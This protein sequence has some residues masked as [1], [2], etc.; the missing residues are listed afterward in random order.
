MCSVNASPCS[1]SGL[2]RAQGGC[3]SGQTG[4]AA[5]ARS[6]IPFQVDAA[7]ELVRTRPAAGALLLVGANRPC[8]GDAADGAVAGLVERVERDLVHADVGPDPPLV[9]V[10]ERMD[11]PDA[12]ALRP[13]H[14]RG[15]GAARR[16]VAPDAGDPG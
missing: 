12:V 9:P 6:C 16:L 4:R 2:A 14:L 15:A 3:Y 8:A 13:L 5:C 11:L 7:L 1:S 10:G